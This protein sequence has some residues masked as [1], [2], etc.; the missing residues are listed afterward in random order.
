[1]VG[2]VLLSSGNV[3]KIKYFLKSEAIIMEIVR[4]VKRAAVS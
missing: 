2:A 3:N 4:V 1:M